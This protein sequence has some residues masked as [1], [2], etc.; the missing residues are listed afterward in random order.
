MPASDE[1]DARAVAERLADAVAATDLTAA[2]VPDGVGL[3]IGSASA[4]G[5]TP[6]A[7]IER[8]D[9]DL[10]RIKRRRANAA[11]RAGALA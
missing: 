11:S 8:A 5:T 3:S 10:Y 9:A 1:K 6:D 2:G 4:V 7:I